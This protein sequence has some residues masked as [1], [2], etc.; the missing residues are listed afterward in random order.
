MSKDVRV[1]YFIVV[2]FF[3]FG[4]LLGGF[5]EKA[6]AS[7]SV[8][9]G[10]VPASYWAKK[11][12]EY[13]YSGNIISGYEVKGGIVFHPENSVTRAQAAKIIVLAKGKTEKNVAKS[14]FKDVPNT[15]W[16]IGWIARASELGFIDGY[17]DG[18]YKPDAL[19][20]RAQMSKVI[21][22]AFGL[23]VSAADEKTIAFTDIKNGFW[24]ASYINALYYNGISNGSGSLFKPNNDITRAQFAV[25]IG[26]AL[27][28]DFK[29][30]VSP[31]PESPKPSVPEITQPPAL[32]NAKLSG[33]VTVSSLNVRS[34]PDASASIV[35]KLTVGNIV[36]V[37]E[38]NGYWAKISYNNQIAYVHKTYL[39]LKNNS[40]SV[41]KDRVIVIDPG[42][43][44]KD[45][46]ASGNSLNEKTVVL[47]VAKLVQAK[48]ES[49]GAKIVMT[50][51]GDTFPTLGDRVTTSQNSYGELFVSIHANAASASAKGAETFY[52][53]SANANGSESNE[54]AKE[55][56]KQIVALAGMTDRGV[57]N[58]GFYV[59]KN[60][61]VPSVL[62]ELGFITNA[63][64]AAK[65]GSAQYQE[66]Y[67]EAIYRG[68]LNYYSK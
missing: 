13:L 6:S 56:Q 49:Q 62:V 40:G 25:F 36:A 38:I 34:S 20:T 64:D 4:T 19:L 46:G 9:F 37:H 66:L 58:T 60:Q 67:A 31:V 10:D 43:G 28:D 26:R 18:T 23:D 68:I 8:T 7:S 27:H 42:H 16:A 61:N 12:I 15:H 51:S 29:I 21:A 14:G 45:P 1:R 11:E 24:A 5:S 63:E 41:L 53:D 35:G 33:K 3:V 48:L 39:K 2:C 30:P 47:E 54:L 50:R 65:L 59:I 52:D 44:G 17:D 32:E 22:N 57:K 55:I